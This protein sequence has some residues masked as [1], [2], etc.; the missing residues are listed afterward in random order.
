MQK[1]EKKFWS[2]GYQ[3]IVGLDEAG[4]GPLAGP[5]CIAGVIFAPGQKIPPGINDSKK[6]SAAERERL[7][8]E[9]TNTAAHYK[10]TF[11]SNKK[12]DQINILN[13][14]K[15]GMRAIAKNLSAD[16]VLTD[17]VNINLPNIPQL[18]LT[19]G[20]SRSVSIAAA[21]ILAKVSRDKKMKKLAIKY[22]QYQLEK[23]FGYPTKKHIK[24]IAKYG[25]S[26]IHRKTFQIKSL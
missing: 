26:D 17:A 12:I 11:V 16:F 4:R 7:F 10:I 5:V 3:N 6:L 24:A 20:D 21:S 23:H 8:T 15:Q 22:P 14:V 25:Y 13:A 19:K 9:I 18:A 1:F 2:I